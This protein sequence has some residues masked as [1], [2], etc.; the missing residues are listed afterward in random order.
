MLE[1]VNPSDYTVS[2]ETGINTVMNAKLMKVDFA[3]LIYY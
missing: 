1:Q 3:F 2:I